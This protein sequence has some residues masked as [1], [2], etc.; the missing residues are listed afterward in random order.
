MSA[1]VY[2]AKMP[3]RFYD[4]AKSLIFDEHKNSEP[5]VDDDKKARIAVEDAGTQ[6]DAECPVDIVDS[7]SDISGL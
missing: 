1:I 3:F 2:F 6:T 7:W 5:T 4:A